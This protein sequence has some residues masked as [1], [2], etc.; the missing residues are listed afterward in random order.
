MRRII[1]ALVVLALAADGLASCAAGDA[2]ARSPAFHHADG[3]PTTAQ[4]DAA[5]GAELGAGVGG[6]VAGPGGVGVGGT[7]G[8]LVVMVFGFIVRD[9]EKK[10]IADAHKAELAEL[11]RARS[12][13]PVAS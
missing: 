11:A 5:R 13:P 2:L 3:T 4:E 7:I 9:L 6:A 8:A 1:V 12:T 10:R